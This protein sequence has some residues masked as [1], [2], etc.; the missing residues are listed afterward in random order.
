MVRQR[1]WFCRVE[2]SISLGVWFSLAMEGHSSAFTSGLL[3]AGVGGP[4]SICRFTEALPLKV[5][6]NV[7]NIGNLVLYPSSLLL[8][9]TREAAGAAHLGSNHQGRGGLQ[10]THSWIVSSLHRFVSFTRFE[11]TW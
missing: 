9:V 5:R 11:G 2:G 1:L 10:N 7:E 8:L 6:D 3:L 4:L